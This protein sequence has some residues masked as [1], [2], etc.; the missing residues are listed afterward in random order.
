MAERLRIAR[1]L[2][3]VVAHSISVIAVQAGVGHHVIDTDPADARAALGVIEQTSRDALVEMRRMLGA[4]RDGSEPAAV[5]PLP[6]LAEPPA[7]VGVFPAPLQPIASARPET[8]VAERHQARG[9]EQKR[10]A[11]TS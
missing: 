3:D 5:T 4:L 2:H 7:P 8:S 1:E 10:M 6:G 9:R 11:R